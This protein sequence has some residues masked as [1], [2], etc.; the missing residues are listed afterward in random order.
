MPE[1][2]LLINLHV[3]AESVPLIVRQLR[4]AS[5][6]AFEVCRGMY[7]DK[8]IRVNLQSVLYSVRV[9]DNPEHGRSRFTVCLY[10]YRA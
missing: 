6:K 2:E 7:V 3:A 1:Q 5:D 9:Y 8:V 4:K 10:Q